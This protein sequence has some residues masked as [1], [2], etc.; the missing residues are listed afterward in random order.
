MHAHA[1]QAVGFL[2][3]ACRSDMHVCVSVVT[4]EIV[5]SHQH[6]FGLDVDEL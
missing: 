1:E 6:F 2:P 3:Q 4:K 5:R